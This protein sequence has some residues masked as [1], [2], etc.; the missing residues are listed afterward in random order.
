MPTKREVSGSWTAP[1]LAGGCPKFGTWTNNPQFALVPSKAGTFTVTV[2]QPPSS[3]MVAMGLVVLH[4]E[5]GKPPAP[6]IK[7]EHLVPGGKSK[8][9]ATQS[10]KVEIKLEVPVGPKRYIVLPSTYEPGSEGSFT[11]EV[12]SNDD[13]GF[14]LEPHV[15]GA[16]PAGGLAPVRAAPLPPTAPSANRARPT[17]GPV[18]AAGDEQVLKQALHLLSQ[19]RAQPPPGLKPVDV[20]RFEDPDFSARIRT[21]NAKQEYQSNGKALYVSGMPS[22]KAKKVDSWARLEQLVSQGGSGDLATFRAPASGQAVSQFVLREGLADTWLAAALGMVCVRPDLVASLLVPFSSQKGSGMHAL[23]VFK[24]GAWRTVVVD[25]LIPTQ[26]RSRPP[27]PAY[28]SSV[29][30]AEGPL[31]IVQ[32][33]LAKMYGC[34]EH[35]SN[36]RVGM[37]LADLTGGV[38]EAIYLRDGVVSQLDGAEKQPQLQAG[39]EIQS[40]AMWVRLQGLLQQ[41]HLLGATYK[42]KYLV[43]GERPAMACEG[44]TPLHLVYPILELRELPDGEGGG[45]F[46]LLRNVY[47]KMADGKPAPVWRGAWGVGAADWQNQPGIASGLGGQPRDGSFWMAWADFVQGF[48]KVHVCRLPTA[49]A[50]WHTQRIDGE[51]ANA[52]AGGEITSWPG[53]RWRVNPQYVL[54][55]SQ[56]CTVL[57]SLAQPDAQLDKNEASDQYPHAIGFYALQAA[58]QPGAPLRRELVV[59]ENSLVAQSRFACTRQ[60]SRELELQPGVTYTLL[61]CTKDEYVTTTFSLCVASTAP[62]TLE[63]VPPQGWHEVSLRGAWAAAQRTAGGC[64]NNP[65]TWTQNPQFLLQVS[66]PVALVGVLSLELSAAQAQQLYAEQYQLTTQAQAAQAAGDE[67]GALALQQR[68]SDVAPAIGWM[69]VRSDDMPGGVVSGSYEERAAKHVES[70]AFAHGTQEVVHEAALEPGVYTLIPC[71]YNAGAEAAFTLTLHYS[72]RDADDN[73]G[74]EVVAVKPLVGGA[75]ASGETGRPGAARQQGFAGPPSAGAGKSRISAPAATYDVAAAR[76]AAVEKKKAAALAAGAPAGTAETEDDG[77]MGYA[78]RMELEELERLGRWKENVPMFTIEGQPLSDNVKKWAKELETAAL[79]QCAQS[80]FKFEDR[81]FPELPSSAS[82][83]WNATGFPAQ[84]GRAEGASQ[85]QCYEA[86]TP[87]AGMPAVTHWRRPEEFVPQGQT[88]TMF[89]NDWEVEGII[90]SGGLDNRWFVSALNIVAGN[91]DQL[92]RA[93]MDRSHEREGFFV[94]KFYRD[95]PMSD[96]DW[97]VVIVDDRIPCDANGHPAFCRNRD[98]HV[99]WAMIVEKA[100]AKLCGSYEAMQ[101]GTVVQGLEDLTGGVGYK[102]DLEKADKRQWIPPK[103]ETPMR[104]WEEIMEK[105]K[106]EHVV[107]CAN[108]TKGQ[109]RP[110]TEKKGILLNRAYAVVTGGEFEDNK[111]LKMRVP[112]NVDG[113]AKE[114]NGKWSDTSAAWNSRLRQMLA[115]SGASDDGTFWI[116]YADFVKHYNKVYMCRMLD[117]LWT[118]ITVKSRW[119]D[120]TAGGCTNFISWRHNNQWLLHIHRPATKLT[121]KLTQPDARKTS[122]NGRHYSNAIGFYILKG[123]EGGD[124]YRRKLICKDGDEEDGGDFV[125]VKEPRFTRQVIAEYTFEHASATPYILLPYMFEPGREALFRFTIL[126]DDRDDDGQA[127]FGFQEI[128]P[129]EDWR[130][131]TLLDSWSRGGGGNSLGDEPS[132]GGPPSLEPAPPAASDAPAWTTNWQF[133]IKVSSRTRCF[134]FLEPRNIQTDMREVEGL[135]PEPNYPT[136][137]FWVCSGEGDHIKLEGAKPIEKLNEAPA[138]RGDGVSLEFVLEPSESNY[139][140]IPYMEAPGTEHKYALSLYTDMEHVFEKIVPKSH[141]MDCVQCGNPTALARVLGKLDV[142]EYKYRALCDKEAML[143][144]RGLLGGAP[145]LSA[146]Q[147]AFAAADTN[148]DGKVDKDEFDRFRQHF[149]TAD[150]DGDGVIS[151]AELAAYTER[152][153]EHAKAQHASYVQAL[154]QAQLESEKL[155]QEL[156]DALVKAGLQPPPVQTK[157][158]K[159]SVC[160]LL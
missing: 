19:Q 114:W 149:A 123:N 103:G 37:G 150:T 96:D 151:E 16:A 36:G 129:E 60:V 62:V 87:G 157:D 53:S 22:S 154:D 99:Y 158:G 98:E 136:V 94:L 63:E 97:A 40:G 147:R 89:K 30:P 47:A 7:Q 126:S 59:R 127:D 71:T 2:S 122:G 84:P 108:N 38:S 65:D 73:A 106:T 6:Q 46:V 117:D 58:H 78:E 107:G 17:A 156:S 55:A 155:R 82:L 21:A 18:S 70:S 31:S 105:M 145:Q 56:P 110:K 131:T 50:G 137:G 27:P 14:T 159:S 32:K 125:Y 54:R 8:Y 128:K 64:P 124:Q 152:V 67:E 109:A 121:I 79:A 119:M 115:F 75:L 43:E 41:R 42:L 80:G 61:P 74:A 102:F 81:G 92:D 10:Q 11:I 153:Q 26:G 132:A 116:E 1:N 133:Q 88:P 93:F 77:K 139:V 90:Q 95:D 76:A 5:A 24:D 44:A 146:A 83:R 120:E 57:V 113:T 135:Q 143:A 130:K 51:W 34:Y 69:L 28:S 52:S 48:N 49:E 112:L 104:L 140:V 144:Q 142:L 91:R 15:V 12:S 118:R 85:P 68:A 86:G 39:V 3:A 160:V 66:A 20:D 101:G 33:A 4:G 148:K 138:R 72:R 111:L 9:K 100:Y 134:L 29:E 141:A 23:R 45:Q 13:S 25:D 35:L